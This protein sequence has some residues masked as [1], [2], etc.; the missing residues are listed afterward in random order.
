MQV[1]LP[2]ADKPALTSPA[3]WCGTLTPHH[4]TVLQQGWPDKG[5][6]DLGAG[7][8]NISAPEPGV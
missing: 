4:S 3:A 2:K 7:R 6:P 1:L 8:T 5:G